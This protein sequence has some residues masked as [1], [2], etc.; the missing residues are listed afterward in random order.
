MKVDGACLC[1]YLSFEAEIDPE[2]VMIFHCTDCQNGAGAY[3]A[4]VLVNVEDFRLLSG[5]PKVYM[6]TS[7]AGGKRALSFCPECGTNLHGANAE[8]P[9]TYSLRLGLVNQRRQLQP[10]LQLWCRSALP[11]VFNLEQIP[12][13]DTQPN[14][15]LQA[16]CAALQ[17]TPGIQITIRR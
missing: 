7:E 15:K 9:K 10:K 1:G 2:K 6:K 4:G 14:V 11:W 17:S 8:A 16:V 5:T 12:R 3:R 13:S